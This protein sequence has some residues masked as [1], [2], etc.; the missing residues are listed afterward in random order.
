M[1]YINGLLYVIGTVLIF[2]GI[3]LLQTDLL[4]GIKLMPA[5]LVLMFISW[6]LDEFSIE[7]GPYEI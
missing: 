2:A 5:G 7:V 6:V 3:Y 1:K 4:T